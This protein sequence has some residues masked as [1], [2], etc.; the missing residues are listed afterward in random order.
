MNE[1]NEIL[2]FNNVVKSYGDNNVLCGVNLHL[3]RG[4]TVCI[5]GKNGAG[6]STLLKIIIGHIVK[7][8]GTYNGADKK[9]SALIE[10]P[11]FIDGFSGQDNLEYLLNKKQISRAIELAGQFGLS[12]YI[13]K[14]V[15]KYSNGM[16]QKLALAIALSRS[17]D[18]YL[19]D[20]PFNSLDAETVTKTVEI[21]NAYKNEGKSIIIV[22]HNMSRIDSYC[23]KVYQLKDGL[24]VSPEPSKDDSTALFN[25][26]LKFVDKDGMTLALSLLGDFSVKSNGAK[27]ILVKTSKENLSIIIKRVADCGLAGFEKDN[28]SAVDK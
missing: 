19:L 24:L 26:R 28:K 17:A 15:R 5:I 11:M 27:S 18:I 21:I 13:D 16:K 8:G 9:L 6:K 25:Y 7:Y 4:K 23:D 3:S 22:T 12:E 2:T 14:N 10:T 1:T 20:E